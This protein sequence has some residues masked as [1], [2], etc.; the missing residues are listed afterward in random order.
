MLRHGKRVSKI[1]NLG[2]KE[3]GTRMGVIFYQISLGNLCMILIIYHSTEPLF[4]NSKFC[5]EPLNE[6]HNF[7]K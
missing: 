1:G 5:L 4:L 6:A 7:G 2:I 3:K